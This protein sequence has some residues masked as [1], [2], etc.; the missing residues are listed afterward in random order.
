M[1]GM[2]ASRRR[3]GLAKHD[4]PPALRQ[5]SGTRV[6]N[7]WES[8]GSPIHPEEIM[9]AEQQVVWDR[10]VEQ[11]RATMPRRPGG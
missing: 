11:M 2:A 1:S 7:E 10:N 8:D 9:T 3:V 4:G 5:R 6:R